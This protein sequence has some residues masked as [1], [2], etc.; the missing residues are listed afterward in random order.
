[1]V[2]QESA[3]STDYVLKTPN[4]GLAEVM[5]HPEAAQYV[6]SLLVSSASLSPRFVPARI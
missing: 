6:K 2:L 3:D 5:S 1:M 4:V